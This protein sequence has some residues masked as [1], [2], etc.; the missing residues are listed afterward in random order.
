MAVAMTMVIVMGVE[1][2]MHVVLAPDRSVL[3]VC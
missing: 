3:E 1:I 2:R